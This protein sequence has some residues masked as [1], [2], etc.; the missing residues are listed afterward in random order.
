MAM[1]ATPFDETMRQ[2]TQDCVGSTKWVDFTT[3]GQEMPV[4]KNDEMTTRAGESARV[5]QGD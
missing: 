5:T 2:V 4:E 1:K 3:T